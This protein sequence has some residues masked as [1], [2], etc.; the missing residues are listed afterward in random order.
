MPYFWPGLKLPRKMWARNFLDHFLT[1]FEPKSTKIA[2]M[3]CHF[4][5]GACF[6]WKKKR[7]SP[8]PKHMGC[9][10]DKNRRRQP[11]LQ[12]RHLLCPQPR[13]LQHLTSQY[14][15]QHRGGAEGAPAVSSIPLRC[16][17]LQLSWLRTQQMSC[18][19]PRLPTAVFVQQTTHVLRGRQLIKPCTGMPGTCQKRG[20]ATDLARHGSKSCENGTIRRQIGFPVYR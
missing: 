12:T 20:F 9:L 5:R 16:Q 15:Q 18:L 4:F 10:L 7:K 13:K 11:W 19:Q 2:K 3:A 1:K 17:M 8:T 6:F 14:H